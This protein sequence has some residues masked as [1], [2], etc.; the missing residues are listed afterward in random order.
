MNERIIASD[1]SGGKE[2]NGLSGDYK[3][4]PKACVAFS[5]TESV[6]SGHNAKVGTTQ[7]P[8]TQKLIR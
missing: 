3:D 2:L 4:A 6:Q 8:L 1:T 5:N 7:I